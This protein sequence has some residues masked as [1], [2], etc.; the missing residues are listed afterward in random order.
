[1]TGK[2]LHLAWTPLN[3]QTSSR[4]EYT[5]ISARCCIKQSGVFFLENRTGLK[6]TEMMFSAR[7][8]CVVLTLKTWSFDIEQDG[9]VGS[10]LDEMETDTW[11][12]GSVKKSEGATERCH[13]FEIARW[14]FFKLNSPTMHATMCAFTLHSVTKSISLFPFPPAAAESEGKRQLNFLSLVVCGIGKSSGPQCRPLSHADT[15]RSLNPFPLPFPFHTY[16]SPNPLH[17]IPGINYFI[18]FRSAAFL[19]VSVV[20]LNLCPCGEP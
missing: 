2:F 9:V 8:D 11:G 15:E 12:R 6:A 13:V 18:S 1:M 14:L 4:R 7:M 10:W 5:E 19:F 16:P 17:S 20:R 3:K